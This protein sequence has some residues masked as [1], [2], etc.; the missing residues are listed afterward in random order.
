M[1]DPVEPTLPS[2]RRWSLPFRSLALG[3]AL[4][5]GAGGLS[6]CEPPD[7]GNDRWVT[8]ENTNVEI[9]W[10]AIHKA[11]LEA[12]GPE[13]L[14]R[15]VNEIYTGDEII[16]VSVRD[17]DAKSQVVTGFFD[18]N[19]SG[20]VDDDEKI[21][22]INREITGEESGQVQ[23]E[24]H[25]HYAHYRSPMWDIASGMLLGSMISRAFM[26]TYAP[27]YTTAYTTSPS[28]VSSLKT[29]R[30]TY[31]ANNP[32]K[33]AKSSRSGRSYGS[34]GS[35]FGSKSS[36]PTRSTTRTRSFGGGRFGLGDRGARKRRRL[37]A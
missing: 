28:R 30:S 25:G 8:T 14:E 13:D 3:A 22:S 9:D 27:M 26:P 37:T 23:I 24:G 21:F 31:R 33:F 17:A 2:I 16:S 29:Q 35:A 6:A 19:H 18:R 11:Y 10:D 5:I 12:E 36:T 1:S 34:K 32:G 15:R 20:T 7:R 4:A